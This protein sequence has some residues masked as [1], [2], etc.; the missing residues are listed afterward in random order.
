MD[1]ILL[2]VISLILGTHGLATVRNWYVAYPWIDNPLHIAG[3][4]FIG[5][6][7]YYLFFVRHRVFAM[8][9]FLPVITLGLGFV[10]LFGVLW[11]FYEFFL[12]VW[13]FHA[14]PLL[15]EPGYILFDTLKDLMNDL[16]GGFLALIACRYAASRG[17]VQ[18]KR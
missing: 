5:L 7:F 2:A 10:A 18:N 1:K 17:A 11:E 9:S 15:G 8:T 6:L 13:F 4:I 12:D 3:G 14:H 16:I